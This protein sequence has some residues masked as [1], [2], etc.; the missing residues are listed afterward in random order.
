MSND[1]ALLSLAGRLDYNG[2]L[3][4]AGASGVDA[5]TRAVGGMAV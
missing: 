2:F 1:Q 5:L 4:Q 3:R